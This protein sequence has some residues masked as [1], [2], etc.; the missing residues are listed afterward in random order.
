M[1]PH[2]YANKLQEA[3]ARMGDLTRP[4]PAIITAT[5]KA[6]DVS[7]CLQYLLATYPCNT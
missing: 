3:A 6:G 5:G 2:I 4:D 1:S 7:T